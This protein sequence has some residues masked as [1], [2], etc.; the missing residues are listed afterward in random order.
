MICASV[1]KKGKIFGI[2]VESVY[3]CQAMS[4]VSAALQLPW[5]V[6]PSYPL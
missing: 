1:D 4:S 3:T 6:F 5:L 2:W